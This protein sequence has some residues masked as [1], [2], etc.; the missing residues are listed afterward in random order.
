MAFKMKSPLP[1]LGI[2]KAVAKAGRQQKKDLKKAKKATKLEQKARF[3]RG[4]IT[5]KR[6]KDI[7]KQIKKY[8]DY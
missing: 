5:R 8:K 1:L 2:I 3:K 7:K 4:D 6:F